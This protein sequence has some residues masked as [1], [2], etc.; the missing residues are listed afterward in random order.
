MLG[1]GDDGGGAIGG[2]VHTYNGV[3]LNLFVMV[4]V[5]FSAVFLRKRRM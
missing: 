2:T 1:G 3:L 4:S 5:L